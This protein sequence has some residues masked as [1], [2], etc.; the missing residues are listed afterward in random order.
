[1]LFECQQVYQVL[2][3]YLFVIYEY[4]A[5]IWAS[6][7]KHNQIESAI[8]WILFSDK[9]KYLEDAALITLRLVPVALFFYEHP[10]A[11]IVV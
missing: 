6:I 8:L 7:L 1:M 2:P 9:M 3:C 5:I 10:F 11:G 4:L